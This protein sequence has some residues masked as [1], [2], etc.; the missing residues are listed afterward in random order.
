[1]AKAKLQRSYEEAKDVLFW[2]ELMD[3]EL[4]EFFEKN[5]QKLEDVLEI[6]KRKRNGLLNFEYEVEVEEFYT[7]TT[8]RAERRKATAHKK[9]HAKAN[10]YRNK[11]KNS[12]DNA[13]WANE[14]PIKM[15]RYAEKAKDAFRN[16]TYEEVVIYE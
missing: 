15:R 10:P 6:H 11:G 7:P 4:E 5:E 3:L 16:Y 1:M 13:I 8:K 12:C 14:L 2:M 9:Q